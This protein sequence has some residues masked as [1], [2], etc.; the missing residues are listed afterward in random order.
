MQK[1]CQEGNP[2]L[3][4]DL[5]YFFIKRY[6]EFRQERAESAGKIGVSNGGFPPNKVAVF[7][8]RLAMPPQTVLPQDIISMAP[9][10][11][12]TDRTRGTAITNPRGVGWSGFV[13]FVLLRTLRDP[14]R[15]SSCPS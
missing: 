4:Y 14:F 9:G 15:A 6:N 8:R 3:A 5:T 12:R 2:I 10:V 1:T 13:P 11:S 7:N